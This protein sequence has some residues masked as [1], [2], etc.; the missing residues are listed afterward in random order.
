VF[1]RLLSLLSQG[2]R[3]A[4]FKGFTRETETATIVP[5][6][7]DVDGAVAKARAR[8]KIAAEAKAKALY[9]ARK[10]AEAALRDAENVQEEKEGT[11]V[12]N[13]SGQVVE[14]NNIGGKTRPA[15]HPNKQ[16]GGDYDYTS[17]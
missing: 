12:P 5:S 10:K 14:T 6:D 11:K 3:G 17:M 2:P 9:E 1:D 16:G 7:D 8:A 4:D 15:H 13:G